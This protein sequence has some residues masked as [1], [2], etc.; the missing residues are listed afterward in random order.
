VARKG[1]KL[2]SVET[3]AIESEEGGWDAYL[4]RRRIDAAD[5]RKSVAENGVVEPVTLEE[6][7]GGFRVIAGFRRVKAAR[8][9]G[10]REIPAVIY[11]E[12]ALAPKEAFRLALAS[13]AP[14]TTLSDA[15]KALALAKAHDFGF[16]DEK[17]ESEVAPL[18][19]L[20]RSFKVVRRYL[21]IAA[22]PAAVV[23]ALAEGAISRQHAEAVAALPADERAWFFETV[24]TPLHL[25][26][27][28]TRTAVAGAVDLASR[29]GATPKR[30]LESILAET[31]LS[32]AP[33]AARA[34]FKARLARSLSP[35]IMS[36]EDEFAALLDQLGSGPVKIDHAPGFEADELT[37]SARIKSAAD[38]DGVRRL[39]NRGID[40]GLF[41]AMLSLARRRTESIRESFDGENDA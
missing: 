39:I 7:G 10:L 34:D 19:G 36:M 41:E 26:A 33:A 16:S 30:A 32:V 24:L 38:A 25:S 31:D 11:P 6:R 15:D 18:L 3:A 1:W 27:G 22:M 35:V 5:I 20:P 14:G 17:I 21:E 23:D 37:L 28:D 8:D 2:K 4:M 40:E 13:N 29:E 9:A 12:G